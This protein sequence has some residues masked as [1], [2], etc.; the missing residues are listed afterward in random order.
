MHISLVEVMDERAEVFAVPQAKVIENAP[1][2][3]PETSTKYTAHPRLG[4]GKTM[5]AAD[6]KVP[7]ILIIGCAACAADNV[8]VE[9]VVVS[10]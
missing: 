4:A 7:F 2:M 6:D 9:P 10:A 8:L 5:L 1:R 3:I